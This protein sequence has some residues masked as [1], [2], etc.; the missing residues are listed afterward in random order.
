M[1]KSEDT[2]LVVE[3]IGLIDVEDTGLGVEDIGLEMLKTLAVIWMVVA[4][5]TGQV[6]I[7]NT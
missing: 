5:A 2:E 1:L 3:D 4:K 7:T 6:V